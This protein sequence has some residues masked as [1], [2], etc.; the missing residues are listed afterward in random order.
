[1]RALLRPV[2]V[3]S[4]ALAAAA[5]YGSVPAHVV[6]GPKPHGVPDIVCPL[7]TNWNHVLQICQ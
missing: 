6:G 3:V 4:L 1:M 2:S 7:G 5:I